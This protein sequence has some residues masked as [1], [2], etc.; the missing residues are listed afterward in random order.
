MLQKFY[1]QI[2]F[3]RFNKLEYVKQEV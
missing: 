3:A 2:Q 1:A